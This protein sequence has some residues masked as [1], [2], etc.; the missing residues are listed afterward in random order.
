MKKEIFLELLF[1]LMEP[2]PVIEQIKAQ[3]LKL[4]PVHNVSDYKIDDH[5]IFRELALIKFIGDQELLRKAEEICVD[6][7][8]EFLDKTPQSFI[9]QIVNTQKRN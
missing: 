5:S 2:S 4:V 7:K 1:L 9:V 3:L 8:G 6:F